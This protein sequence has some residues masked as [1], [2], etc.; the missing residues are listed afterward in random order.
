MTCRCMLIDVDE[1]ESAGQCS[2]GQCLMTCRCML[3][4]VDECESAGQCSNGQCIN[5]DGG[6]RCVCSGGFHLSSDAR[7]CQG[8]SVI[9]SSV[10]SRLGASQLHHIL[11]F[12]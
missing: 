7:D 4:D 10:K 1:C 2:N 8:L 6:Y 12:K 5:T 3:I 9:F 11:N